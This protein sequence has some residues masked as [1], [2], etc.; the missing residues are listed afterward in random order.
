MSQPLLYIITNHSLDFSDKEKCIDLIQNQDVQLELEQYLQYVS[1][2]TNTEQR[3]VQPVEV[4]KTS[5]DEI[6][7]FVNGIDIKIRKHIIQLQF[8][9]IFRSFFDY[10]PLRKA[11]ETLLTKWFSSFW[12]K[13]YAA[14]PSFWQQSFTEIKNPQHGKRLTILQ[15]KIC[16]YCVSYKRTK[17][18]LEFCL[19]QEI[20]NPE[21]MKGKKYKAW[22]V[23]NINDKIVK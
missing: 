21:L 18:N 17:L 2:L 6:C 15:D 10:E 23:R 19:S 12:T 22:F 20:N 3:E 13:E 9:F 8:P 11:V 16:H 1:H 4:Q 14:Y 7:F 5:K